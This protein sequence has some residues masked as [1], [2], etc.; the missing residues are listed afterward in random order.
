M[1]ELG[2]LL[3]LMHGA[4]GRYTT[5]RATIREW[6][7]LERSQRAFE[8]HMEAVESGGRTMVSY[9][10]CA[11]L[12][13]ETME[14]PTR[15]WLAP[16]AKLRMERTGEGEAHTVVS[17]GA[18]EWS[19]EPS[20]GAMVYPATSGSYRGFE[21]L[22]DPS[23]L[24][25]LLDLQPVGSTSV[26]G[27]A[28]IL[29]QARGR[30]TVWHG[31][32][33]LPEGAE[34]HELAVDA[35]RGVLMRAVS[36]LDEQEFFSH[37]VLEIAF[38]ESFPDDTFVFT[39]PAGE[40]IRDA[41]S[42]FPPPQHTTIEEAARLAPFT[43]LLPRRLPEGATL[44]VVYNPG[45]ERVASPPSVNLVYW[46]EGAGHSLSIGQTGEPQVPGDFG[47]ETLERHGMALRLH[48]EH[49]QRLLV[50]ERHGTHVMMTSDLEGETLVEIA[51]S[52][53]PAPTEPP[54]LVDA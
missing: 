19:Y 7:H 40:E 35:E 32:A 41:E 51:L 14:A 36:F 4:A 50:C 15:I 45:S 43:V 17:D 5:L 28:A 47:E 26:A 29:V 22:T 16:P 48:D 18:H 53:E 3:E 33:G 38:D 21:H 2:D 1:S 13:P 37:E 27:R 9:G 39:P 34:R 12:P 20:L 25:G 31:P 54:R 46:F 10:F 24:L 42:A 30:G 23:M 6:R 11:E 49:R 44:H 8:R 52:L